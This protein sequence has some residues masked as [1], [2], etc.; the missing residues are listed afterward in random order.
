MTK[1]GTRTFIEKTFP[2]NFVNERAR[3]EAHQRKPVYNIHRWWAKRPGTTFRAIILGAFL[4]EATSIREIEKLFYEKNDLDGK[5][6]VDPLAG[7]GTTL[8]EGLRLNCKM[9]GVDI[10]PVAW[11]VMKKELEPVDL[12]ALQREFQ[13]LERSVASKIKRYYMTVCPNCGTEAD[14]I[15]VFWV[16]KVKCSNCGQEVR[17]FPSFRLTETRDKRR[18]IYW[19]FCPNCSSI[20]KTH[21]KKTVCTGCGLSFDISK[22]YTK[23]G[24]YTC[25]YC[26][27]KDSITKNLDEIP[28]AEIFAVEYYCPVC[29]ARA[30]K[31]ADENDLELYEK[32]RKDFEEKK[33]E[34]IFPRQEIPDGKEV[35]RL[36]KYHY[37]HFYDFFNERQLL[38]LSIL[39]QAILK[40]ENENLKE[41]MLLA[42]SDCLDFNNMFARYNQKASKIEPMF[43]HHAFYPKNMPAENNVWGTKFGRCSFIK[44]FKK[45]VKGKEYCERPY[46]LKPS[47]SGTKKIYIPRDSVQGKVV[48]SFEDLLR[49][50]GNVLLKCQTS[51]VLS[52]ITDGSVDAIVTDPPYYDNIM[53]SELAD[54]YYVWLRIALKEKYPFFE[55]EYCPRTGEII[56]NEIQNK[57]QEVFLQGLTHVFTECKRILKDEGLMVFTFHHKKEE[58]WAAVL[59]AVLDSGFN[60]V[61]VYP[62]HSEMRTSFHIHGKKAIRYDTIIVCRKSAESKRSVSWEKLLDE[63]LFYVQ[64]TVG[65]LSMLYKSMTRDDLLVMARGK[66]LELFS[67]Y[68]PHVMENGEKV[69]VLKALQDVDSLIIPKLNETIDERRYEMRSLDK[70]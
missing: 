5:I 34:L 39:L 58:A 16:R 13:K 21:D 7:G 49:N 52:T 9:I 70:L 56:V 64:K 43:A 2:I 25:P 37:T 35:R 61:S 38:C 28:E 53:Y 8:V 19:A 46:E 62:V 42:F 48:S 23:F 18:K 22:G 3:I 50:K 40:I 30:Y 33:V 68:Y 36:F 45:L 1:E 20:F 27:H 10:N 63:I 67:K 66:C 51:E 12:Q 41:F 44:C 65:E 24:S 31:S 57:G 60:I 54:F 15:Y 6:I 14:I 26:N 17:L 32:A 69:S 59:K 47:V 29:K 11:F 4:D 55:P